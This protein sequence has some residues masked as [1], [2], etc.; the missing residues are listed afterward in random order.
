MSL[1]L[2]SCELYL[3]C[4]LSFS[5]VAEWSGTV[6][7]PIIPTCF[8]PIDDL[9]VKKK[10]TYIWANE[11]WGV[12]RGLETFGHLVWRGLDGQVR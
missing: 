3:C 1:A 4:H 11:I 7:L 6:L 8:Y 10:K 2:L 12:L 9:V 5:F